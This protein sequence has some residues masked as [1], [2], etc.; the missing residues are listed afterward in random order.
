MV[1]EVLSHARQFDFDRD[2]CSLKDVLGAYP[3]SLEN[4]RR[5]DSSSG[6]DD[7]LIACDAYGGD[8]P[9]YRLDFDTLGSKFP[10]FAV[11]LTKEELCYFVSNKKVIICASGY[12]V[13]MS[14]TSV[15]ARLCL[16]IL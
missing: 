11:G 2:V 1:L 5:V 4:P 6:K 13:I 10:L 15:R 9:L 12:R 7:F 8:I 14:R 16:W 3:A